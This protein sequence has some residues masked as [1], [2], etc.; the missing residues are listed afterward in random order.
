MSTYIEPRWSPECDKIAAALVAFQGACPNVPKGETA[1]IRGTSKGGKDY[2]M[3]Y[4]YADIAAC[5]RHCRPHLVAAG[6]AVVQTPTGNGIATRVVHVSGQWYEGTIAL[7]APRTSD[8]AQA[9]GS[10]ITYFR[11]YSFLEVLGIAAE[12]ED[13]DGATATAQA[14]QRGSAPAARTQPPARAPAGERG[15]A[16]RQAQRAPAAAVARQA[17]GP[18][19]EEFVPRFGQAKG[20]PIGEAEDEQVE[21]LLEKTRKDV[22]DPEK[23]KFRNANQA[24]ADTIFAVMQRRE[25]HRT[26]RRT[27]IQ[28]P[29]DGTPWAAVLDEIDRAR[30]D[31]SLD[32]GKDPAGLASGYDE[33]DRGDD[34]DAY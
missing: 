22:R 23:A 24:N 5:I 11:R 14:R 27:G 20:R 13:D 31:S 33:Y 3:E 8:D 12:D 15:E 28:G 1:K 7:P 26:A 19:P 21:W 2:E 6:L 10:M 16:P 4:S 29:L 34:P 9:W 30:P 18:L 32:V 17:G 25:Q